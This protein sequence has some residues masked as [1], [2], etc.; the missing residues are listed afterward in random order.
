M[1]R[2]PQ[3][4]ETMKSQGVDPDVITYS[5][6]IK[7]Y[8]SAGHL[9]CAFQLFDEMKQDAKLC[10]DEIVYNSLLDG[11]GRKQQV[12]KAK[13]VL[14]DMR[15]AGVTPSNY[16]LSI[17]VKFL[18]RAHHLNDAF[19]LMEEFRKAYD[20]TPNV[21]VY[22]CLIQ[23]CLHN[24]QVKKALQVHDRMAKDC[25]P[26]SKAYSVLISGCIQHDALKEAVQ[27][28]RCAYLLPARGLDLQESHWLRGP[29]GVDYKVLKELD[30]KVSYSRLGRDVQ[31]EMA[32][33]MEVAWYA[34]DEPGGQRQGG[35]RGQYRR[36]RREADEGC[37]GYQ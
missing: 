29:P 35:G 32:E 2:V 12:S 27:V 5:T 1:A 8:C 25:R 20:L 33:V 34:Y 21:Q 30:S 19:S 9:D 3:I 6:L 10:L 37:G 24:K 15:E 16:T 11:C 23:A 22:T 13:E 26:D 36:S 4:F 28:A 18:G 14:A 31:K 7:G 17:M